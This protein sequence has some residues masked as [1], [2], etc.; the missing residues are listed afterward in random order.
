M[1]ENNVEMNGKYVNEETHARM[2]KKLKKA[3]KVLLILGLLVAATGIALLAF[4]ISTDSL[5][6][7]TIGFIAGGGFMLVGGFGMCSVAGALF[8]VAHAR[9]IAAFGASTIAPIAGETTNYLAEKTSPGVEKL[10]DA[11]AK[12]VRS[13]GQKNE[14]SEDIKYC[15]KCG[16]KNHKDAQ[17]CQKCGN[18]F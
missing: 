2:K 5:K 11:I 4:G 16:E 3:G 17:F 10:A 13:G 14:V 1:E 15:T 18:K 9:E 12:G 7:S 6:H 8:Y